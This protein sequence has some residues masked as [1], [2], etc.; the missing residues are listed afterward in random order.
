MCD[1]I[2][3]IDQKVCYNIHVLCLGCDERSKNREDRNVAK[4]GKETQP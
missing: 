1:F 3:E 2:M 4:Y